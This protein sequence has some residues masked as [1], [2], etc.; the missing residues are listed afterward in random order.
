[1]NFSKCKVGTVAF[2]SVRRH[3]LLRRL[4]VFIKSCIIHALKKP[5]KGHA[6]FYK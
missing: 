6:V 5:S 3:V 1:M 2:L 4:H